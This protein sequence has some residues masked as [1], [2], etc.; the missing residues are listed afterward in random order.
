MEQGEKR[1]LELLWQ[2]FELLREEGKH[3]QALN[4]AEKMLRTVRRLD[5][6]GERDLV[7]VLSAYAG[8]LSATGRR[9]EAA[10][11]YREALEEIDAEDVKNAGAIGMLSAALADEYEHLGDLDGAVEC[12][13]LA[14]EHFE[15]AEGG[16]LATASAINN[17]AVL[18]SRCGDME[19]AERDFLRAIAIFENIG[20]E[21]PLLSWASHNLGAVLARR[22]AWTDALASHERGL[23]LR[24]AMLSPLDADLAYSFSQVGAVH[25]AMGNVEE[26]IEHY[27]C[28]LELLERSPSAYDERFSGIFAHYIRMLEEQ[29]SR[30]VADRVARRLIELAK[31]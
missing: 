3:E 31:R 28:A 8:V 23:R 29:Q 20:E 15:L 14:V 9:E 4:L 19:A 16:T 13:R 22:G 30:R 27:E 25:Q 17:L 6:P 10:R 18:E 2:K 24:K 12:Q 7:N 11:V 26:A 5:E 1:L 21:T